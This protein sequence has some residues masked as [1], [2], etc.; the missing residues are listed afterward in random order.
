LNK[1]S[2]IR[3]VRT[4]EGV[5]IDPTGKKAGRGAYLHDRRSCWEKALKGNLLEHALKTTL[6]ENERERLRAHGDTMLDG[7]LSEDNV[8]DITLPDE[9]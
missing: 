5:E 6:T 3:L 8:S 4:S 7:P 9:A 1:R 2:L